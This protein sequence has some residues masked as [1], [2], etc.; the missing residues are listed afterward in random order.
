MVA[1]ERPWQRF[2]DDPDFDPERLLAPSMAALLA[3]AAQL[4]GARPCFSMVLPNGLAHGLSFAEVDRLSD[5]CAFFLRDEAGLAPGDAVAILAPNCL[6][7]PVAAWGVLKAGLVLTGINPLY[8]PEEVN[9][10][11]CD[12]GAKA[13]FAIDL[14]GD[15]LAASIRGSGVRHVVKLSLAEFF[16]PH[17]RLVIGAALRLRKL[18]PGMDVPAIPFARALALGR[19]HRAGRPVSVLAGERDPEAPAIYQYT[20]GTTGRSKGAELSER[21]LL[22]NITQAHHLNGRR[23]AAREGSQ[24]TSLLVLPLYHVYALA[25]G[26]M[27][28]MRLG[29]HVVLVPNPRPLSNLRAAFERFEISV[30]P[31]INTLFAGLLEQDWFRARP[32]ASL[33]WCFSG[34]APLGAA[35]REAW[36]ELTG[37][38]IFE[39]YGLT[40]GTCI[41]TSSPL[42]DTARPGTVGVPL[43]GTAIRIVDEAGREQPPGSPGEILVR[44]PQVMRGYLGRPEATAET[45]RD[46]WLATGD[47]GSLDED[48]FLTVLD[49]K[50]DMLLVSGFNV[51]PAEIEEVLRQHPA[52]AE[53]AVVGVPDARSGEL[54][55]AFLVRREGMAADER[56]VREHAERRLTRYKLPR[57]WL[58]LDALPKSPV[59]KV[60]RRELRDRARRMAGDA[61]G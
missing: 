21:N 1:S 39:G 5:D 6:A 55:W 61:E 19:R 34:A 32:P 56:D 58:F 44:G 26:A 45:I 20:G 29:S 60:L 47:I 52:I 42:D 38:R 17:R 2:Y 31:G 4:H 49:R 35:T 30:L 54:P 16:P 22:A 24:E 7:W 12:S 50:K 46:G 15:R 51:Y 43:P 59:G 28:S 36:R 57:R 11:L 8:T 27:H 23:L 3:E 48:G 13:L 25:I 53:A 40:E 9:H 14:F 18:L 10:Q 41:V 33:R 37:C